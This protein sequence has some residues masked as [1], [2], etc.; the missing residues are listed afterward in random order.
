MSVLNKER[1]KF[2][3]MEDVSPK[4]IFNRMSQVCQAN[5]ISYTQVKFW[6]AEVCRGRKSMRDEPMSGRPL[7][8]I[9][10]ENISTV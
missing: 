1:S 8:A 3:T 7:S 9:T 10:E 5:V 6:A 4:D 2:L